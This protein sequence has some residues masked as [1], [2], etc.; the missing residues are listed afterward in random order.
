MRSREYNTA[1]VSKT[2][3][4]KM[5]TKLGISKKAV[6][7]AA[8]ASTAELAGLVRLAKLVVTPVEAESESELE[9]ITARD[10]AYS[11]PKWTDA[12]RLSGSKR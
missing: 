11:R 8:T 6:T 2:R 4:S 7:V 5:A 9:R 3:D 10:K 1:L 12:S